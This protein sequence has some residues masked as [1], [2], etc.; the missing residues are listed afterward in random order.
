[1][2]R[3]CTEA[4]AG[5]YLRQSDGPLELLDSRVTPERGESLEGEEFL[6]LGRLAVN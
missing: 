1:M 6:L 3:E 5:R 2:G 4:R